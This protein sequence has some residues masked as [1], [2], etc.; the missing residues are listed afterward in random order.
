MSINK[1]LI[2]FSVAVLCSSCV[3]RGGNWSQEHSLIVDFST[4]NDISIEELIVSKGKVDTVKNGFYL[5]EFESV[6]GGFKSIMGYTIER[7]HG[8]TYKGRLR[9][10]CDSVTY[11]YSVEEILIWPLNNSIDSIY[12]APKICKN[13]E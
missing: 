4:Y 3:R 13:F 11:K 9:V 1:F 12:V 10:V 2:Y 8:D 7:V 6:R 5:V